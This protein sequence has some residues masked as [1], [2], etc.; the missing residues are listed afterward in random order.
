MTAADAKHIREPKWRR[1]L[2]ESA[3]NPTLLRTAAVVVGA[4][5]V[6]TTVAIAS[7]WS[8]S[9]A[10]TNL[11]DNAMDLHLA[12]ASAGA[13]GI[14]RAAVAQAIV[15]EADHQ[16]GVAED[17]DARVAFDEA[18]ASLAAFRSVA[19][20]LQSPEAAS[21]ASAATTVLAELE[22]ENVAMAARARL[23]DMEP[24][25]SDLLNDLTERQ[26]V[27]EDAIE[28][29]QSAAGKIA[30]VTRTLTTLA[31]PA[32]AMLAY[33]VWARRRLHRQEVEMK[34][35]VEAERA[36]SHAKDEL[37]AGISHELRTPLTS[38]HGFSEILMADGI[39][40]RPAAMDLISIIH[41]ESTE[42]S[43]MVDDL[44]TAARIDANELSIGIEPTSL[45]ESIDAVLEPFV[46]HG[47][48]IESSCP[49][50]YVAADSLR[51]RQVLRNLVSNANRHG[52]EHIAVIVEQAADV[53]KITVA[54]DGPGVPD[55]IIARLFDRFVHGG[56]AALLSGSV[57]LGLSVARELV[58]RMSG[59]I[60]Y[61]RVDDITMFNVEIP[62]DRTGVPAISVPA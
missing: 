33:W 9:S 22:S 15:F 38:I 57:G 54:D 17:E 40:D 60:T 2:S 44:L 12:N 31:I 34:S 32:A 36:I 49:P 61:D 48:T 37:I 29:N 14:T 4:L 55:E 5:V 62:L 25:Y 58:E 28:A 42:L 46:K 43:R 11:A 10:L 41:S 26:R 13:A 59:T 53:A 20:E 16:I 3:D 8:N 39:D 52:G 56:R 18:A 19:F 51:L 35:R 1:I 45:R 23:Q 47:R 6:T 24:A 50:I 21:F 30:S 27:A 7:A